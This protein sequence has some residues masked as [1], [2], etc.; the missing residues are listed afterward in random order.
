MVY[1][2]GKG[3][4]YRLDPR[5]KLVFAVSLTIY[6]AA[7]SQS[8]MLLLALLV[9]HIL[10]MLSDATRSQLLSLWRTYASL[11]FV[12][13][14]LGGLRWRPLDPLVAI[15]PVAFTLDA[16]WKAVGLA[17]RVFDLGLAFSLLL[18]TTEPGD[19]VA[20]LTRMGLPF[21]LG[22]PAIMALQYVASLRRLFQHILEAQ[23]SRGLTFSRGNPI[24][25]ARAYIPVLIP[26][27]IAALRSVDSLSLALQSR[28]FALNRQRTSRRQLSLR[29]GDWLFL[30]GTWGA[31]IGLTLV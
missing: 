30:F 5:T 25:M 1:V 26:L 21:E 27:I 18:W 14:L 15:G 19:A 23:Q 20:G 17:A 11:L 9:L 8:R 10:S 16:L 22:F 4:L 3:L 7:E 24:Q 6:L 13:V 2:S 29:G 12:I 28:G 31:L